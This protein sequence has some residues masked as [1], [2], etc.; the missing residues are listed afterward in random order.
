MSKKYGVP[1]HELLTLPYG[2]FLIDMIVYIMG[3]VEVK[4]EIQQ[5]SDDFF[6]ACLHSLG[7]L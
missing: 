1:P 4:Q 7:E 5:G 2:L 3:E 6:G